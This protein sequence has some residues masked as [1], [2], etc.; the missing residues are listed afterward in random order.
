M[1]LFVAINLLKGFH[2][3][4][5]SVFGI[6]TYFERYIFFLMKCINVFEILHLAV[7]DLEEG[8]FGPG[9]DG[10]L[11]QDQEEYVPSY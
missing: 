10:E 6:R 2:Y 7:G 4:F 8:E 11:L 1:K 5:L 9:E 3:I